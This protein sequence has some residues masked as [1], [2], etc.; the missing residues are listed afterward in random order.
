MINEGAEE[1]REK[2]MP[3]S[4]FVVDAFR[5]PEWM[6]TRE[7]AAMA[8]HVAGMFFQGMQHRGSRRHS[9]PHEVL[10]ALGWRRIK[11]I[12]KRVGAKLSRTDWQHSYR[13]GTVSAEL[14]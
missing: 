5:R 8:Q 11:R 13:A 1:G 6:F 4:R 2:R 14:F 9:G 10:N 3:V 12:S 7:N